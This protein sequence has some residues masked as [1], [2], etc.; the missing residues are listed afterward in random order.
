MIVYFIFPALLKFIEDQ[1]EKDEESP[2]SRTRYYR[3]WVCIAGSILIG[4]L[5]GFLFVVPVAFLSYG[6]ILGEKKKYVSLIIIML[7]MTAFF[8]VGF[9]QILHIPVLKGV[10]LD[11]D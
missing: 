4:Y 1:A 3:S 6:L 2:G 5:F 9:Y 7:L 8:Y 11:I 10:F